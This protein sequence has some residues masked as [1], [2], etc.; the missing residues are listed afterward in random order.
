MRCYKASDKTILPLQLERQS[1]QQRTGECERHVRG[2][3]AADSLQ[4]AGLLREV[5]AAEKGGESG[6]F[7]SFEPISS[8]LYRK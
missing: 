5:Q 6:I 2:C 1:V 8:I 3:E 7:L 4:P